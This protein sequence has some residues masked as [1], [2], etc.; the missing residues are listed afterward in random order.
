MTKRSHYF[1][2]C[3][4]GGHSVTSQYLGSPPNTDAPPAADFSLASDGSAR[5]A[6]LTI[7]IYASDAVYFWMIGIKRKQDLLTNVELTVR[8]QNRMVTTNNMICVL[9]NDCLAT[10]K[11]FLINN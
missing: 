2:H 11:H 8:Y 3:V 10:S 1:S 9:I 5:S 4:L 6:M 7:D